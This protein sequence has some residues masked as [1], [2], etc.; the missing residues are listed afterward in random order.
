[1]EVHLN[2][3]GHAGGALEAPGQARIFAR[4]FFPKE[5]F[6]PHLAIPEIQQ[7]PGSCLPC[8][9]CQL[10]LWAT[11]PVMSL[12]RPKNNCATRPSHP[13]R[14]QRPLFL[15]P[16]SSLLQPRSPAYQHHLVCSSGVESPTYL[17]TYSLARSP[18]NKV[19]SLLCLPRCMPQRY[20]SSPQSSLALRSPTLVP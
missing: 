18:S 9:P 4:S 6:F 2:V 1:M 13:Q 3:A 15:S 19:L 17:P 16:L 14:P 5:A 7:R 12:Q 11:C 8:L 20:P 10:G